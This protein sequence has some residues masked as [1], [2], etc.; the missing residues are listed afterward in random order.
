MTVRALIVEDEPLAQRYLAELLH[1]TGA[2]DVVALVSNV[3]EATLAIDQQLGID[4]AF[5]DV[6]LIDRPGDVSGLAWARAM[7]LR[8]DGPMLVLATALADHA[9]AAFDAG[10]VDYLLKPFTRQRVA[11]CVERLLARRPSSPEVKAPSRLLA[12]TANSLVFLPIDG[13]L[14]FEAEER[15]TYVHHTQ[16]RHL[17]D[18][19]LAALEPQ[20]AE[21]ILRSHRNWLVALHHVRELVRTD[22]ELSLQVGDNL[23]V[24]VSRDRA[25]IVR[26]ALMSRAIG[27]RR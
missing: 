3:A 26:E 21:R 2:V 17:V 20:F 10:A 25:S 5:V 13:V 18:L 7:A 1:A 15:L 27:G 23:V 6:R 9:I 8:P 12:R 22:G 4:V 11:V 24:P 14:A 16:G 19:S